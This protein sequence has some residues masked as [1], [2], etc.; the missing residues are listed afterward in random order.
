MK[1][2]EILKNKYKIEHQLVLGGREDLHYTKVREQ[3]EKSNYKEDI[4]TPGYIQD[5]DLPLI[6][7]AAEMFVL[8]SFIEGFGIIILEAQKCGCPVAAS[9]SSSIPEVMAESGIMFDPH[10]PE[11][12]AEKIFSVL[13]NSNKLQE[14]KT[15]GLEN[16]KRFTWRKCAEKT[17][18]I[19]KQIL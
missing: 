16:V 1:A 4:I 2:F 3:I 11:N 8:P 13:N 12:M 15:K 19:Y 17:L 5:E 14:L 18:D 7:N 6:Y 9:N 10:S